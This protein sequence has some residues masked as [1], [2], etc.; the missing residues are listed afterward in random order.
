M[1]RMHPPYP[2]RFRRE[3]VELV[4][5]SGR[6]GSRDRHARSYATEVVRA[7]YSGLLPCMERGSARAGPEVDR[8]LPDRLLPLA[9]TS[10][11]FGNRESHLRVHNASRAPASE[12]TIRPGSA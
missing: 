3:A 1:P 7:R 9:Q 4:R 10:S 12:A 8:W 6:A 11:A 2:V 5:K